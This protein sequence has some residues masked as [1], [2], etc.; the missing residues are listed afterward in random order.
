M[1]SGVNLA[2]SL[3]HAVLVN[4]P[5]LSWLDWLSARAAHMKVFGL[6]KN[7]AASGRRAYQNKFRSLEIKNLGPVIA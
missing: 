1:A 4:K 5:T 3:R 6:V 2:L 7:I